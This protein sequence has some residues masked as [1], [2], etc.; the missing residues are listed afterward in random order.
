[1]RHAT[2]SARHAS[3]CCLERQQRLA[4]GPPPHSTKS[5]H[6]PHRL[7]L[8]PMPWRQLPKHPCSCLR[9]HA[10]LWSLRPDLLP[11]V[12]PFCSPFLLCFLLTLVGVRICRCSEKNYPNPAHVPSAEACAAAAQRV[13]SAAYNVYND[14]NVKG[15]PQCK[16]PVYK[17][18]GC[19]HMRVRS[20]SPSADMLGELTR[21]CACSAC[22][23]TRIFAGDVGWLK[24]PT[25]STV[26]C[27]PA[28]AQLLQWLEGTAV[29]GIC[30]PNLFFF[31]FLAL[32]GVF[33]SW[34]ELCTFQFFHSLWGV[35]I[36]HTPSQHSSKQWPQTPLPLSPCCQL[37]L[38]CSQFPVSIC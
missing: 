2:R 37:Q 31:R 6:E 9:R 5:I 27:E 19:D 22:N 29:A 12:G 20:S 24:H 23:V 4:V 32:R 18:G 17:D 7:Q 10:L 28:L 8:P 38:L 30:V 1:M 13:D 16:S 3:V 21:L 33:A 35:T 26:T 14:S 36:S 25:P 11:K 15:C 34:F